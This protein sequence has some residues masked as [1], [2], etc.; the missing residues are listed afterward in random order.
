M[1][2]D[3]IKV[4]FLMKLIP[5]KKIK[6]NEH[7]FKILKKRKKLIY[8]KNKSGLEMWSF[9]MRDFFKVATEM[10]QNDIHTYLEFNPDYSKI[11]KY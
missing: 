1:K 5:K 9:K 10:F 8:S 11:S 2:T 7:F 6:L 3:F 4:F